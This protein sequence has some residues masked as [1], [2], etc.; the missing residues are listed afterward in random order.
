MD[1]APKKRSLEPGE[2]RG[3]FMKKA[4]PSGT[5]TAPTAGFLDGVRV[6]VVAGGDISVSRKKTLEDIVRRHGADVA[7][8]AAGLSPGTVVVISERIKQEQLIQLLGVALPDHGLAAVRTVTSEWVAAGV[9]AKQLPDSH[10]H[11]WGDAPLAQSAAAPPPVAA[12]Q[13]EAPRPSARPS[14][15]GGPPAWVRLGDRNVDAY[16]IGTLPLGVTYPDKAQ[17]P[18]RE[19]AMRIVHAALDAGAELVDVAGPIS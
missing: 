14:H 11:L 18:S 16:G 15:A 8:A 17:R 9:R 12:N 6:L 13:G 3:L 4:K 10:T 7:Q 19:E 2:V 5:E 1:G